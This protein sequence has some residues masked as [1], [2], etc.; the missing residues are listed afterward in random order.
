MAIPFL[1]DINL[2][3][4]ELLNGVIH[5]STSATRPTTPVDGQVT[6]DTDSR[7][8]LTW[9]QT[10]SEW[11]SVSDQDAVLS[12]VG[13]SPIQA[14]ED[15]NRQV[16]ISIDDATGGL[17]PTK[18]AIALGG[19][20]NGTG[21]SASTPVVSGVG[22]GTADATTA[23]EIRTAFDKS[24]DQN[25][26]TG[27]TSATFKLDSAVT[28]VTL[29]STASGLEVRNSTDSGYANLRVNDLH[30]NGDLTYVHSTDVYLGDSFITL[31]AQVMNSTNNTSG[32][33]DIKR[34]L[35]DEVGVGNV[36]GTTTVITGAGGTTFT[37]DLSVGDVLIV[38]S[39]RRT[40]TK[41]VSD[42]SLEIDS[43]FDTAPSA[44]A[45]SFANQANARIFFD[46]SAG[47]WKVI[48]GATTSLQTF[49]LVRKFSTTI[50]D[51]T[52]T[53]YVIT[54][55]LNTQDVTVAVRYTASDYQAVMVDWKA[56]S[57]DT[58]TVR[59]KKAPP[60]NEFRV[61]ITG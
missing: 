61:V 50:G 48:D 20:L 25:T 54:H 59:F 11:Q 14:S 27:T 18:G 33:V 10:A 15:G 37:A 17:T 38:G 5:K 24:H 60:S 22:Y 47:I 6:F 4:N 29:K 46:H 19:D 41:I 57:V 31:N 36:T 55:N 26:D 13:T 42:T 16:T 45:Y 44:S 30:V 7:T 34:L 9:N 21:T 51:G 52:N 49:P 35:A 53:S 8:F 40:V 43:A 58:I 28:G 2:N 56:T 12:V 32:G 39:E 1:N 3:Q 23:A